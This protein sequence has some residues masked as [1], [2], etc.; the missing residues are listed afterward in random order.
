M[1]GLKSR[2]AVSA[3]ITCGRRQRGETLAASAIA[4]LV[5]ILQEID[6]G[7]ERQI[8]ARLAA[9]AAVAKGRCL[10]LIDVAFGQGAGQL[11]DGMDGVVGVVAVGL[12]GGDDVGRVMEV[13][14]PFAG[15]KLR[16]STRR[17]G[18]DN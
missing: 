3:S 18:A 2:S 4:G 15:V 14:V 6:E 17:A 7:G 13:V 1:P 16:R 12:A 11:D 9:L 10:A 8:R 5:V